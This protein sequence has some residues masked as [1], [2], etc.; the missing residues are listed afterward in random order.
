MKVLYINIINTMEKTETGGSFINKR[1]FNLMCDIYGEDNLEVYDMIYY[2]SALKTFYNSL[3]G[4]AGGYKKKDFN[5]IV[6]IINKKQIS[7]VFMGFSNAGTLA[8]DLKKKFSDIKIMTFCQN[9]QYI[10]LKQSLKSFTWIKRA[11]Y[12]FNILSTY[13]SEK[14]A[15]KYSDL[16]ITIN[17]RDSEEFNKIYKRKAD[18]IIPISFSDKF[19]PNRIIKRKENEQFILFVGSNFFGNTEGLFWFIENCMDQINYKLV[20]V[21]SG[22]DVY[23]G[24]YPE[25][26]IE[27]LGFVED[28]SEYYYKAAAL[29]LPIISGSGMKTKTCEAL[30]Y[31]KTIFGTKEAFQGYEC[32]YNKIGYLCTTDQDFIDKINLFMQKENTLVFNQYSRDVFKEKYSYEVIVEKLK[33]FLKGKELIY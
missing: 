27:F 3:F 33:N 13:T 18:Y 1:N 6:T 16:L 31:G 7:V 20:V 15:C 5:N 2:S 32:D 28:L 8:K 29:V 10:F 12:C 11:L 24:K 17:K 23:K 30:M 25:K 22:M 26:N 19:D 21:G 4:R 9:N 14:N